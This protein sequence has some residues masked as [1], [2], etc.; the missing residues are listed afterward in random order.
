MYLNYQLP[1]MAESEYTGLVIVKDPDGT[2]LPVALSS[3]TSILKVPSTLS[4]GGSTLPV[5]TSGST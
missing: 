5:A 4:P 1:E 3:V 2:K